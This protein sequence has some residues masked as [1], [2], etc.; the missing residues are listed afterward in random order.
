MSFKIVA[1]LARLS[2]LFFIALTI[3]DLVLKIG[4]S[5]AS[6]SSFIV[7]ISRSS[8]LSSLG[9]AYAA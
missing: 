5:P 4:L 9:V 6:I 8:A 2:L 7:S 1:N 3:S